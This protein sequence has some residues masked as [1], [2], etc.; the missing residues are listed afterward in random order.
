M[1]ELYPVEWAESIIRDL[2]VRYARA[3][4]TVLYLLD[5]SQRD[6]AKYLCRNDPV[7]HQTVFFIKRLDA[8]VYHGN[9]RL[10]KQLLSSFGRDF[11]RKG[12]TRLA[13]RLDNVQKRDRIKEQGKAG[14]PV[15]VGIDLD[16]TP[17]PLCLEVNDGADG[18]VLSE[19][20]A[21]A[22]QSGDP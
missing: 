10:T 4:D 21:N 9:C 16:E 7:W 17:H 15:Q 19:S 8:S 1:R 18:T 3:T 22:S 5:I 14:G 11:T 20:P 12:W 2:R 6:L 13:N